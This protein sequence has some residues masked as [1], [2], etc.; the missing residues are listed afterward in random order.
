[1]TEDILIIECDSGLVKMR[2]ALP[3]SKALN[4][5]LMCKAEGMMVCIVERVQ[6]VSSRKQA[7]SSFLRKFL[8]GGEIVDAYRVF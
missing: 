2:T 5:M 6:S 3:E 4:F 7:L 8:L 1:M